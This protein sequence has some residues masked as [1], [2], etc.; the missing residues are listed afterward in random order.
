MW[1][2]SL[3]LADRQDLE[4]IQKAAVKIILGKDYDG[5]EKSLGVLNMESLEQRRESIAL[6]FVKNGLK[7]HNF[8]KLFPLRKVNHGMS[9]R[10]SERYHVKI[11]KTG[12]FKDSAVPFLQRLLNKDTLAKKENLKRII[13]HV[14][15]SK[16]PERSEI[17]NSRVNYICKVDVI[18]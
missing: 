12:R 10:N 1:H 15:V 13:N 2:S 8:S 3:T 6:K 14:K 5:Y 4:R 11:A 18:T 16:K 7:N 9:A 17:K